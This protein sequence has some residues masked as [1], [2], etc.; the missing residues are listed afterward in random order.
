MDRVG[1]FSF[2]GALQFFYY[3]ELGGEAAFSQRLAHETEP[4]RIRKLANLLQLE[5]E[6]K[7]ALR[8]A[9]VAAGVSVRE[10]PEIGQRSRERAAAS[11]M[12]WHELM[13]Y[14]RASLLD[15][16][17]PLFERYVAEAVAGGDAEAI[18]VC[19]HMLDHERGL[20]DFIDRE[21]RGLPLE[22]VLEPLVCRLQ[23]PV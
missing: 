16:Y 5:T 1:T 2:A 12:S 6:T 13:A 21:L 14:L 7:A 18:R 22:V 8:P 3:G 9:M 10:P 23:W 19:R 11:Q 20:L 15:T 17:L 4:D